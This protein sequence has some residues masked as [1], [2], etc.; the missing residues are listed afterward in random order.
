MT[1]HVITASRLR[2]GAILWLGHKG[3]WSTDFADALPYDVAALEAGLAKGAE[4]VDRQF[5]TGFMQVA[6]EPAPDGGLRPVSVRERIRAT[7]PSVRPDFAYP[8]PAVI[9]A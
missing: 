8:K 9:G 2:D 5:V 7:G 6:V 3:G 1:L 4:A